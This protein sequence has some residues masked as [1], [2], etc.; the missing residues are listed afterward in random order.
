MSPSSHRPVIAKA[1]MNFPRG[2]PLA[3]ANEERRRYDCKRVVYRRQ[4]YLRREFDC[5]FGCLKQDKS[6]QYIVAT[7][8][9]I[10]LSIYLQMQTGSLMSP[11]KPPRGGCRTPTHYSTSPSCR[12]DKFPGENFPYCHDQDGSNE[13]HSLEGLSDTWA[14]RSAGFPNRRDTIERGWGG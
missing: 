7:P 1:L 5:F 13:R 4:P 8:T 9:K 12:R 2:F 6:H 3:N 14:Y 10:H 11:K